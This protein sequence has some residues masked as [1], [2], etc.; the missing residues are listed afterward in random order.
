MYDARYLCFIL[1]T[2]RTHISDVIVSQSADDVGKHRV[3]CIF[4]RI[5]VL[6]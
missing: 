6:L 3:V 4:L 1:F 5:F 2:Y